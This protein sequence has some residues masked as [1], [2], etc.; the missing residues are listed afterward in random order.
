MRKISTVSSLENMFLEVDKIGWAEGFELSLK[1]DE[2]A[3]HFVNLPVLYCGSGGACVQLFD[4]QL[5][6][7][8]FKNSLSNLLPFFAGGGLIILE[9]D[10][11]VVEIAV[12]YYAHSR[13]YYSIIDDRIFIS[14]DWRMLPHKKTELNIFQTLYFLNWDSCWNGETYLDEIKYFA[15]TYVYRVSEKMLTKEFVPF[16]D[17]GTES[18]FDSICTTVNAMREKEGV[19]LMLSGGTDSAQIAMAA[20][21]TGCSFKCLSGHIA[22]LDMFDNLQDEKGAM[23]FAEQMGF[24]LD[25]VNVDI[26]DFLSGW[27]GELIKHVAFSYKDG[28]LWQGIAKSAARQGVSLVINGQ[29]ADALYN[30]SYTGNSR[31]DVLMR[32]LTTDDNIYGV[33]IDNRFSKDVVAAW[34]EYNEGEIT[35]EKLLAWVIVKGNGYMN[36]LGKVV[37]KS[38]NGE[39]KAY[40]ENELCNRMSE[41][42]AMLNDGK[43]LSCRHMLLEGKLLGYV[44]GEDTRSIAGACLAN[45][46]RSLQI[47]ATPLVFNA[48]L[49]LPI[50]EEDVHAPKRMTRIVVEKSE[51]YIKAQQAKKNIKRTNTYTASQVW[52]VVYSI[53][54]KEFDL[55]GCTKIAVDK[56]MSLHLFDAGKLDDL[57]SSDI[58]IKMR[59]AWLGLVYKTYCD[60]DSKS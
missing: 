29:N 9:K 11:K 43:L 47:Y 31:N 2:Y 4:K 48:Q 1:I 25:M 17:L 57:M 23:L 34:E 39:T 40:Y 16:P 10:G 44:D 13:Y 32:S 53:L 56:L 49:D 18:L 42:M 54:D 52:D 33:F 15:P 51:A 55:K 38:A 27:N 36:Y 59:V 30:Y 14:D 20:D 35:P 19:G 46:I 6:I 37:D 24:D 50:T 22:D 7:K 26:K 12:D 41:L 5:F 21:R 3:I 45:G 58:G 60:F 28:R 8:Q